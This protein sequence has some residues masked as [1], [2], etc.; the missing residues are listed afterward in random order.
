MPKS[1][2]KQAPPL[3][4]AVTPTVARDA[5]P[6]HPSPYRKKSRFAKKK[7]APPKKNTPAAFLNLDFIE[8]VTSHAYRYFSKSRIY[9]IHRIYRIAASGKPAIGDGILWTTMQANAQPEAQL[10]DSEAKA[11]SLGGSVVARIHR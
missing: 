2:G 1:N 7:S 8:E 9:R 4:F 10:G 6:S 3:S 5:R 11:M